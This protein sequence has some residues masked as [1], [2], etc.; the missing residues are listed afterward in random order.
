[1]I[2]FYLEAVPDGRRFYDALRAAA[3]AKPVVI[4]KGGRT[5]QGQRVALS[6]TG[7]L[8]GDDRM[9]T[10]LS[11]QTGATLVDSIDEFIDTLLA[12]QCLRPR[13]GQPGSSAF[14]VG[15]G[16]GASVL[17]TDYMA[18]IG[19]SLVAAREDTRRALAALALPAGTAID[20]PMD[21][22]SGALR[23]QDGRIAHALI[24]TI[25]RVERPGA[26]VFHINM[27]QFLTNPSIPDSV[28][29]NLVDGALDAHAND[30]HHTPVLLVMRSDGSA[31]ID[32]RKRS[33]RDRATAAGLPVYDEIADA[34][35]AL[36]HF[37][38][39]ERFRHALDADDAAGEAHGVLGDPSVH[40][41]RF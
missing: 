33:A 40:P 19:M 7:A 34:L 13:P 20:N 25:A 26:I 35:L 32:A 17:A 15:N 3:A 8:A 1:V 41:T 27:P 11:R 30:A 2:G 21:A 5:G 12:F 9:W 31:A 16:G 38:R 4:L 24:A 36:R 10:A 6:H 23:M 18:R 37:Q 22:P 29:D 14:L 39:F 28:F